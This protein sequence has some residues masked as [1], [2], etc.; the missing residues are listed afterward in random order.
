MIVNAWTQIQL[1]LERDADNKIK[2]QSLSNVP[3]FSLEK[4]NNDI[5]SICNFPQVYKSWS[6]VYVG[7]GQMNLRNVFW[8]MLADLKWMGVARQLLGCSRW[9]VTG[10][11]NKAHPQVSK[12]LLSLDMGPFHNVSLWDFFAQQAKIINLFA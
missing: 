10:Q 1:N 5:Q 8:V 12:L 2:T 9:F 4:K 11:G 6:L 3:L 7:S